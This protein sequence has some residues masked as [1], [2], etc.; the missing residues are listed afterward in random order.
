MLDIGAQGAIAEDRIDLDQL[1]KELAEPTDKRAF[2]LAAA[3]QAGNERSSEVH[4]LTRIDPW[5][6]SRIEGLVKL[7]NQ[8]KRRSR[9]ASSRTDTLREAK[10]H[11]FS[12]RQIG[13]FIGA[14][15]DEVYARRKAAGI[16]PRVKQIDTLAAEYPAQTNYLY[17]TYDG[18]EDDDVSF[19]H[20]NSVLV[21][22]HGSLP[23]R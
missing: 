18:T 22:G 17:L 6:L 2:A 14:S 20:E 11:G 15:E 21:L 9:A 19:D 4:E 5:F 8:L 23:H 1:K 7:A 16:L 12:D 10:R 13:E 3:F